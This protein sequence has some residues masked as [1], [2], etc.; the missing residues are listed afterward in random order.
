M[1]KNHKSGKVQPGIDNLALEYN[2][3]S[4]TYELEPMLPL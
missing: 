3:T 2:A 1:T 4:R